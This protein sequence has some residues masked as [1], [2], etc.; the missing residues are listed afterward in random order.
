MYYGH[1][2]TIKYI[3]KRVIAKVSDFGEKIHEFIDTSNNKN[4][5]IMSILVKLPL[6]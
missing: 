5:S 1:R 4:V 3:G 2:G 6:L